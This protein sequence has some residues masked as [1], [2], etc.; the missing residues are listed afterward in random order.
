MSRRGAAAALA[1]FTAGSVRAATPPPT[2]SFGP[3]CDAF[4]DYVAQSTCDP[5]AKAGVVDFRDLILATYPVTGDYGITRDCSV[6][7]TSEHKEGR[8]WDWK[9]NH[10]DATQRDI[11]DTVIDWL[12]DTDEH[13]NACALARRWGIMYFIWN[14]EIWGSYRSPNSS[15]KTAGWKAYT[16]SN[17]H[18]DHVHLSWGWPGAKKDTTWWTSPLPANQP[19]EGT[20]DGAGCERVWGW[21]QDPDTPKKS[22]DVHLYFGGPAGDPAA[23]GVPV[24][25]DIHRDDLCGPLGSCEHGFEVVS[26]LSLHDGAKHPVHAYGIDSAGGANAELEASKQTLQCEPVVPAGVRRHVVAPTSFDA[27]QFSYFWD[28]MPLDDWTLGAIP[29]GDVMPSEPLLMHADDGS[30]EVWLVDTGWRRHVPSPEILD[31]WG[32]DPGAIQAW[33]AAEVAGLPEGPPL[34]AR[35]WLVQGQDPSVYVIDD[36]FGAGAGGEGGA[37][38]G[39]GGAQAQGGAP[40]SA[41]APGSGGAAGQAGEPAAPGHAQSSRVIEDEGGCAC[42]Q[43]GSRAS[44]A[45]AWAALALGGLAAR[46]R[47]RRRR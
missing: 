11:A 43:A 39:A 21:A 38:G 17:P 47:R 37:G 8:A 46:R 24:T 26:P 19:P 4:Q 34:R 30:P 28:V 20:F 22:I 44:A 3:A 42:R 25:A 10:G 41:G 18:T 32:F 31:T 6:G 35:P 5:T 1:L 40:G 9:T 45:G 12:L 13:G 36:P 33:T 29:L 7:G 27:W 14:S 15:C 2:P 23:K 16:G